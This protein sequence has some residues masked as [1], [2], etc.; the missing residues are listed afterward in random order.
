MILSTLNESNVEKAI[1]ELSVFIKKMA[2]DCYSSGWSFEVSNV[3]PE[4]FKALK[5]GTVNKR[6]IIA[7]YGS[8]KSIYN[9]EKI[10]TLFRFYHDVTH[11]KLDKGFSKSGGV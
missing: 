10:N 7:G 1:E 6:I 3:A 5:S 11:L 2:N 4:T 9:D 8:N